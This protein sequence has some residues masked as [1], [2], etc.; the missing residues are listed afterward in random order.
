[1]KINDLEEFHG[2]HYTTENVVF[3]LQQSSE[4]FIKF[5]KIVIFQ[6]NKKTSCINLDFKIKKNIPS[7]ELGMVE[8]LGLIIWFSQEY[9]W[10]GLPNLHDQKHIIGLEILAS[11]P[12]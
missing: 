1:M 3:R 7:L 11:L 9:L 12:L 5:L 10:P 4:T 8:Q 2:K 6:D